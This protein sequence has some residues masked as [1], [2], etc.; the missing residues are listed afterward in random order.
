MTRPRR[1]TRT[2]SLAPLAL[3]LALALFGSVAPA[4]AQEPA[5][6]GQEESGRPL[7]GYLA[8]GVLAGLAMW[9]VGR[10]ARR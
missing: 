5:P 8:T 3:A 7:D 1:P 9:S 10:T 4:H 6:E 2:L